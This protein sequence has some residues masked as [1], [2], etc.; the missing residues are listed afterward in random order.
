ML[1]LP[2]F[3][4]HRGSP[5]SERDS[6][7]P[8]ATEPVRRNKIKVGT[9]PLYAPLQTVEAPAWGSW[10]GDL[11]PG[12]KLRLMSFLPH[13]PKSEAKGQRLMDRKE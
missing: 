11:E 1:V 2:T 10:G 9:L 13:L 4:F 6:S 3:P 12:A 8:R 7:S 5:C